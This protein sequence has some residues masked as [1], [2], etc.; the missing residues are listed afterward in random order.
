MLNCLVQVKSRYVVFALTC[1]AP[2]IISWCKYNISGDIFLRY[3]DIYGICT[4]HLFVK[5]VILCASAIYL[6]NLHI[7]CIC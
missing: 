7:A 5:T 3:I 2:F 4:Q 1:N 6:V